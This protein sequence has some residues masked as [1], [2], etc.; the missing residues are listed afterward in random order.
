MACG[1]LRLHTRRQLDATCYQE[2][3]DNVTADLH[4]GLN[5]IVEWFP[6][7]AADLQR[8][9]MDIIRHIVSLDDPPQ[10]STLRRLRL[11]PRSV[12]V[13]VSSNAPP[14]HARRLGGL[15][16]R[17]VFAVSYFVEDVLLFVS[18]FASLPLF[19]DGLHIALLRYFQWNVS[20]A[21]YTRLCRDIRRFAAVKGPWHKAGMIVKILADTLLVGGSWVKFF[22]EFLIHRVVDP[23]GPLRGFI[24]IAGQLKAWISRSLPQFLGLVALQ[25]LHARRLIP[26]AVNVVRSCFFKNKKA[27]ARVASPKGRRWLPWARRTRKTRQTTSTTTTTLFW[28][29]PHDN[30]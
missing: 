10:N 7:A 5:T 14:M 8:N 30:W 22:F 17:C 21:V 12:S 15:P 18:G 2:A 19:K 24:I 6:E 20:F 3:T 1:Y 13:K 28:W 23:W 27:P 25:I 16:G 9:R 29:S 4:E 11:V 26:S